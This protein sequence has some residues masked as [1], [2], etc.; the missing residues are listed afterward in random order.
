[1]PNDKNKKNLRMSQI[2]FY[3][4]NRVK[5]LFL[6]KPYLAFAF[7]TGFLVDFLGTSAL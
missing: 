3:Y 4:A 6:L 5:I 1:M 7:L 2:F